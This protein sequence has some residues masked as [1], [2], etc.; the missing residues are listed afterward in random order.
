M[1]QLKNKKI[2]LLSPFFFPEPISTAR[3]N[4]FLIDRIIEN[5]GTKAE[6]ITLYPFYPE[7]RMKGVEKEYEKCEVKRSGRFL[8]FPKSML[9]RRALLELYFTFH[10]LVTVFKKKNIEY[11]VP[12]FPPVLF[13]FVASLLL[14]KKTY[15]V[16]IVHDLLSVMARVAT[17]SRQGVIMKLIKVIEKKAFD[18][19]DKLVFVSRAMAKTA[20]Q[21][22]NLDKDKIE[23]VYPFPTLNKTSANTL[24]HLFDKNFKHVVY[25]G[26][27]GAKQEPRKLV[28]LFNQ[29]LT[30][31]KDCHCHIFSRGPLF[32]DIYQMKELNHQR[33][34]FHDL[35]PEESLY[36][37][38]LHSNVQV[39]PQKAD[40]A[41]GAIPSKLPN[42]LD[43]GTPVFSI[44]SGKGDLADLI[45]SSGIGF[46]QSSWDVDE[47]AG[48]L[49]SFVD[50]YQTENHFDRQK[51]LL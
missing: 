50:R 44:C 33:L 46:I 45:S 31:R 20:I 24:A 51:M 28:E 38:Y 37:L 14:P 34:F 27:L 49:S 17:R 30:L 47:A 42:I 22:Y 9:L 15:K 11:C 48:N 12:V 5:S 25:S 29:F 16:A 21:E 6:V 10:V 35:V 36:D 26:A 4:S 43:S 39:I 32:D 18:R 8:Y 40:T 1:E 41:E 3:Y 19:C 13:F 2:I 7:W 23:V